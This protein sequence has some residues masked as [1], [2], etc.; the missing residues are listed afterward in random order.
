MLQVSFP[1]FGLSPS[2]QLVIFLLPAISLSLFS[3]AFKDP[4]APLN[5]LIQWRAF[6]HAH[7]HMR[8]NALEYTCTHKESSGEHAARRP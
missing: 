4:G 5:A 6:Q 3:L 2:Y 7:T 8:T 1:F